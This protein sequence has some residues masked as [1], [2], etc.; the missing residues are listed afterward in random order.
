[1]ISNWFG[2]VAPK[3]TP[4]AVVAN[5]NQTINQAL[6][7]PDLA[8]RITEPGNVIGG[9]TPE[10]FAAL[11]AAESQRWGQIIKARNIRPD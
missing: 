7:E 11:I 1:V 2:I 5:L 3:G 10:D 9:G 6:Q 4:K 8:R